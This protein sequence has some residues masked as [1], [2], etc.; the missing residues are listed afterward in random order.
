MKRTFFL[1][2]LL[3]A[4]FGTFAQEQPTFQPSTAIKFNPFSLAFGKIGLLGEYNYKHKKSITFGIGIPVEMTNNNLE[5]DGEKREIKMKTFSVMGGY[6]MYLGK[7]SMSGFYFEPYLKYVKNDATSILDFTVSDVER[8][9]SA[10]STYS[11]FGLGAQL[12]VQ[13]LIAQRVSIDLMILGPEAN[14]SNAKLNIRDLSNLPW[15]P[16]DGADAE[17]EIKDAVGDLPIIG[18]KIK[19]NVDEASRSARAEYS[20]FLPGFRMGLTVGVRF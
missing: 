8:Q 15:L 9:F 16:G 13:F 7:K 2:A 12:G 18:D 1:F 20:G 4:A 10:V 6:R 5:I 17:Q 14:I 11:G 19:V 3:A